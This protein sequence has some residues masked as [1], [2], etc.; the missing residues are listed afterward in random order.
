LVVAVEDLVRNLPHVQV[1][2]TVTAQYYTSTAYVCPAGHKA[3]S[4]FSDVVGARAMPGAKSGDGMGTKLE[5]A[6]MVV[7][8]D[9]ALHTMSV[10][11]PSGGRVRTA[12]VATAQ[13][14]QSM[15]LVKID[16]TITAIVTEAVLIGIEPAK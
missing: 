11:D 13:G 6:E 7:G 12:D 5:A 9:P 2:D 10:V 14:R 4:Q 16:D 15:K 3:S 8:V 1:G